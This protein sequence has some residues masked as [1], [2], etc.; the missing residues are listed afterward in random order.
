M[1]LLNETEYP[2]GPCW[3]RNQWMNQTAYDDGKEGTVSLSV[4]NAEARQPSWLTDERYCTRTVCTLGTKRQNNKAVPPRVTRATESGGDGR[5]GDGPL[6]DLPLSWRGAEMPTSMKAGNCGSPP[7]VYNASRVR[8]VREHRRPRKTLTTDAGIGRRGEAAR[9]LAFSFIGGMPGLLPFRRFSDGVES[10]E[11]PNLASE[12]YFL[13]LTEKLE[14]ILR[15]LCP[16]ILPP[17]PLPVASERSWLA[18]ESRRSRSRFH[19]WAI[20]HCCCNLT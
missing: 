2:R 7:V 3:H 10:R 14:A 9:D 1:F 13:V 17:P 15:T 12:L 8:S 18:S 5:G 6:V 11:D 4:E 19:S 16:V 20:N